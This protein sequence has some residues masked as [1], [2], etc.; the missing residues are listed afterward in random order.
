MPAPR[1]ERLV[2]VGERAD[3]AFGPRAARRAAPELLDDEQRRGRE[4]LEVV[5]EHV[6]VARADA[7]AHVRPVAQQPQRAQH[8]VACVERARLDQQALVREVELGELALPGPV[9]LLRPRREA[10]GVDAVLLQPVDARDDARHERGGTAAEV[11]LA[12]RQVVEVLEQHRQPVGAPERHDERIEP[13]L[14]CLVVQDARAEVC[15]RVHRE[16]LVRA[17]DRVLQERAQPAGGRGRGDERED[18]VGMRA[19]GHEPGETLDED[20]RLAGPRPGD[21]EQRTAWMPDDAGLRRRQIRHVL[22]LRPVRTI[23]PPVA[24]DV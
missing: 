12:Q 8:E 21:D 24:W 16:L 23:T 4:I 6:A 1:R 18:R 13:R 15:D 5:D 11:V 20:G 10:L 22:S 19:V 9:G 7:R 3:V 14:Q 17:V 2:V